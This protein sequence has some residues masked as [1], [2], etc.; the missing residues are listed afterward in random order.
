M[1]KHLFDLLHAQMPKINPDIANGLAFKQMQHPEVYV[2]RLLRIAAQDFPPEVKYDDYHIC[3]P[4]EEIAELTRKRSSPTT[5]ELSRRDLYMVKFK[6]KFNNGHHEEDLDPWCLYLPIVSDG[7]LIVLNG[8]LYQISPVLTDMGLSVGQDE[9]FLKTNSNR[10]KFHR[11][12]YDFLCDGNQ[13]ST[14]VIWSRAHNRSSKPVGNRMTV[15]ADPTL[16]HYLFAKYG[17]TNTFNI[18][19]NCEVRVGDETTVNAYNCPS[20]KWVICQSAFH[21]TTN[22]RP[23]GV[24]DKFWS[25]SNIRLAIPRDKLNLLTEGLIAGF[26]YVLDLFP[27][28]FEPNPDYYDNPSLWR[29]LMGIIYWGQGESEGKHLV[30]INSHIDFLDKEID[31]VTQKILASEDVFVNDIYDLFANL[32]ETY[33]SRVTQ[34]ISQLPSMYGKHLVTMDYVMRDVSCAIN[35]FKFAIQPGK[36]KALTKREVETQGWKHLKSNLVTKITD[37]AHGEVNSISIPGDNK[38][39]KGTS[40]L[41]LQPDSG[42]S[43]T[44]NVFNDGDPSRYCHM[45][46]AEVGS[47]ATMSKSEPTGR[48]RPNP[49]LLL[50]GDKV[51]RNPKF[52]DILDRAQKNIER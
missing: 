25:P 33:S 12:S 45:S 30:D 19:A 34:G 31:V 5:L 17:L 29:I 4:K 36:R 47:I 1:D 22:I 11:S 16:A 37:S 44:N 23:K 15:K 26:F 10:I 49:Y 51:A 18:M 20:D 6:F 2:D 14:Y 24:R 39:F 52:I 8:S 28:R 13:I 7:G 27:H 48:S 21:L 42:G 46:I 41:I 38:I 3:T 32:I 43:K 40:S 9:I 50:D 35:S